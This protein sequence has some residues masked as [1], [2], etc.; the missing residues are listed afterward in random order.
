[1]LKVSAL[2]SASL[3]LKVM[4]LAV[5]SFVEGDWALAVGATFGGL[6]TVN[7]LLVPLWLLVAVMVKLPVFEIVTLWEASTP[8]VNEAVLPLPLESVPVELI[9]TLLLPPVKL[10]TVLPPASIALTLMLNAVPAVCVPI[11]ASLVFVTAKLLKAPTLTVRLELAGPVVVPSLA[12]MVVV[13][14]FCN[15][16]VRVVVD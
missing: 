6:L 9:T 15:V 2:P 11:L 1:M 8:L 3:P 14:A 7:K 16:V 10:V 5:S 4:T 13:S 12:V